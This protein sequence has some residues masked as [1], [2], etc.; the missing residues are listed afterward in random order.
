MNAIIKFV[1]MGF[2]AIGASKALYAV[3][4]SAIDV[5]SVGAAVLDSPISSTGIV[6]TTRSIPS[7]DK[8]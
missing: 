2:V 7:G 6:I 4:T 3:T 1:V 5:A 8:W